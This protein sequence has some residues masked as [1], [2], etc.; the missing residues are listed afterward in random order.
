MLNNAVTLAGIFGPVLLILGIWGIL[1][2]KDA[3]DLAS[4]VRKN[5]NVLYVGAVINLVFGLTILNMYSTW[6]WSEPLLVTLLGWLLFVRGLFI[7]F[8][9]KLVLRMFSM[10]QGWGIF[11][12]FVVILWGLILCRLG[13]N[14]L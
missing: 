5:P 14:W 7:F 2:Q 8:I 4:W 10:K 11:F 13:L 6:T 1:Y 3:K 12:S 9:P